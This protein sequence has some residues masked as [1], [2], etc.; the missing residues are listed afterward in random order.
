VGTDNTRWH[1]W[2]Q[3]VYDTEEG[4]HPGDE[5][6]RTGEDFS[7][8]FDELQIKEGEPID[9]KTFVGNVN[10]AGGGDPG[11]VDFAQITYFNGGEVAYG[12]RWIYSEHARPVDLGVQR[13]AFAGVIHV[14]LWLNGAEIYDGN[15]AKDKAP[16]TRTEL[17]P[18]WNLLSFKSNF[19][20][21]QWQMKIALEG[22][23]GDSLDDLRY[24][25]TPP[26]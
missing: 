19:M 14:Q 21:W 10:Y 13:T 23:D 9:W 22:V 26:R 11:V 2:K 3:G 1:G 25:I 16:P 20:Q 4:V 18:G 12:L 6:I 8:Q 7:A 17:K 5:V 24:A 15:P